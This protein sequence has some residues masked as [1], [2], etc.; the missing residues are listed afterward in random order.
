M[1]RYLLKCI[2]DGRLDPDS[3]VAPQSRNCP[4]ADD[5]LGL[6]C[7]PPKA[8]LGLALSEADLPDPSRAIEGSP[9]PARRLYLAGHEEILERG[10]E[11]ANIC[12]PP[13]SK[14]RDVA[15]VGVERA[16]K[17]HQYFLDACGTLS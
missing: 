8:D 6:A 7:A 11:F 3:E 17:T 1:G 5:R 4:A 16:E 15:R 14:N 12:G 9:V 10:P 2:P 13:A